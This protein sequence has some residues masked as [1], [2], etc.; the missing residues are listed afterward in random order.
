MIIAQTLDRL[1]LV[2]PSK[3]TLIEFETETVATNR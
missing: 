3:V 1:Q 2:D